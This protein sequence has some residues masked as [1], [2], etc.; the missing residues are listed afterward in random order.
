MFL[1]YQLP[2]VIGI[3]LLLIL[4]LLFSLQATKKKTNLELKSLE[5]DI[6]ALKEKLVSAKAKVVELENKSNKTTYVMDQIHK[7]DALNEEVFRQKNRVEEAT[8]IAQEASMVKY[9]FLSNVSHEI[10]TPMNSILVFAEL[11]SREIKE[12]KLLTYSKNILESGRK[13][14]SLLDDVIELSKLESGSFKLDE[15][16]VDIRVL[17]ENIIQEQKYLAHKKGLKLTLEIDETLPLSLIVDAQKMKDILF[18]LVENALKFTKNGYVKLKV[19]VKKVDIQKNTVDM[20]IRVEDSGLGISKENQDKIFKIFEKREDSTELELQG[21]GLG[22]SINQKMATLMNGELSVDSKI[23]VGSTFSLTLYDL[24]IV[25]V[26]A[27]DEVDELSIDFSLVSPDGAN[28]MVIDETE[29]S[30]LSIKECFID[31]SIEVFGYDHPRDAIETLKTKKI[32]LIFIDIDIFSIDENAVSKVIA[33]MSQ[34][35]VVTLTQTSI[36]DVLFEEGGAK[37]IGHLKKPISRVEL[38]KVAVKELNSAHIVTTREHEVILIDDEFD[39][40][41]KEDVKEFLVLH[42]KEVSKLYSKAIATNDL[43]AIKLFSEELLKLAVAKNINPLRS[44]SSQ[45]LEYIDIFA[46]DEINTMM[47]EYKSKI[48]R[49]QSL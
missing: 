39:K 45:L 22:L 25:L 23:N 29:D 15:G 40:L 4:I 21:T 19:Q 9:D 28:I 49:L 30:Q 44:F 46:I 36:K 31:T 18:N 6:V 20:V 35:P 24:E 2:I 17:L 48:N 10:R 42:S 32:D 11:L 26:S 14:L 5:K 37:V 41:D 38:F 1:E 7:I 3:S 43:N 33:K 27:T 8:A 47:G 34:A 16:A 13:L 12:K